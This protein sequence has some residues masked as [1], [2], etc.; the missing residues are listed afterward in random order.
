MN[1][2]HRRSRIGIG[3]LTRL[4]AADAFGSLGL[5]RRAAAWAIRALRET[6]LPLFEAAD[7]GA[8]PSALEMPEPAFA[9]KPARA[10]REVV[11]DY[12][13]LGFSLKAHPVVF[14]RESLD[15][16]GVLRAMDLARVKDGRR[17]RIAGL[18][19]VRQRPGSAKGVMF[20]TLED[21]TG[22]ANLIVWPS[23]LERFRRVVFTAGMMGVAGR[24][25]REG[26]VIHVIAERLVDLSAALAKVGLR[27]TMTVPQQRHDMTHDSG[28]DQCRLAVALNLRTD[29][30]P[31]RRAVPERGIVIRPRNFR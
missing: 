12:A 31:D 16:R 6:A 24:L 29:V 27:N 14:L 25:Q 3:A 23:L 10:G 5:S 9:L 7:T 11:D 4:A 8:G 2:L 20:I 17:V 28:S 19:L 15:R 13:A 18:V 30:D 1:D 21:E 22:A 26:E